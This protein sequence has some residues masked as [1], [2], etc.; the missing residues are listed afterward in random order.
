V[1]P[2]DSDQKFRKRVN[3]VVVPYPGQKTMYE[4]LA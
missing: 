4:P 1:L 3:D 2:A